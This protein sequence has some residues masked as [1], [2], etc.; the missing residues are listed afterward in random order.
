MSK[1][2]MYEQ[3]YR[4]LLDDIKNKKYDNGK[5]LPSEKELAIE[6]GVSRITTKKAMDLLAEKHFITRNPGKGSFVNEFIDDIIDAESGLLLKG[7]T[8][9][10][11]Q[12][13]IGVIFDT[14][15][16]D[17]GSE[18]LKSIERECRKQKYEMLFKCTYG[19]I[20]EENAA[21]N[22][23]LRAGVKG[24]ILMCAQGE[25][26]NSTILRLALSNFPIILVDRQM[27]GISIPCIKTDN[28]SA[29]QELTALL[30]KKGHKNLCFVSHASLNTPTINE[31]YNGFIDC[32][33]KYSEVRGVFEKIEKYNPTPEDVGKEY[34]EFDYAEIE[35]IIERNQDCTAYFAAEYK[36]GVLLSRVL[37]GKNKIAEIAT[38]DGLDGVYEGE[39]KF[40]HAKQ[41]EHGMGQK[42]VTALVEL[43]NGG[44]IRSSIEIP[45][46]VVKE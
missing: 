11:K 6:Y 39:N 41:N 8:E 9:E 1:V 43:I 30:I 18:L 46:E 45:Y 22:S 36:M 16:C 40:L 37:K 13:M 28:F 44:K 25:I 15:G 21:I 3:I 34:K 2:I 24:L 29:A 14:F 4:E 26:Y 5:R 7:E 10:A 20:D 27:K 42:A 12:N 32:I 38:F 35:Q 31:R 19:S 33:M 17:F 23:A